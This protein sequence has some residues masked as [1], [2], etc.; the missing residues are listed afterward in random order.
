VIS[1]DELAAVSAALAVLARA[2]EPR[3]ERAPV[4]RWRLAAR[5]PDLTLEELRGHR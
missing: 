4:S 5:Q 3:D 1:E 2:P